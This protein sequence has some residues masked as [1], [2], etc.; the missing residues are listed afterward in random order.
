MRAIE[1][2]RALVGRRA[3]GLVAAL[4]IGSVACGPAAA[5]RA[6]EETTLAP[7]P[8]SSGPSA[9]VAAAA[10][11]VM[12]PERKRFIPPLS[13]LGSAATDDT[14]VDAPAL[15]DICALDPTLCAPMSPEML[16]SCRCTRFR[17]KTAQQCLIDCVAR[18]RARVNDELQ[19]L[20]P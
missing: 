9:S 7:A 1:P 4:A 18:E 3:L 14:P 12:T 2:V 8:S 19:K 5:D 16:A 13:A 6:T 17:G 15:G 10:A 20:G 11:S